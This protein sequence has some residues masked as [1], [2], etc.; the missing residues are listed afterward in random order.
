MERDRALAQ[1]R[2]NLGFGERLAVEILL[3]Q[4]VIQLGNLVD[5]QAA[6]FVESL[7]LLFGDG[8]FDHRF[9][10]ILVIREVVVDRDAADEVHDALES[11]ALANGDLHRDGRRA[12]PLENAVE[13]EL[14]IRAELVHFVDETQAWDT[15]FGGLPPHGFRLGLDAFLAIEDGHRAV[16][17]A[18]GALDLG[19]EIDVA[20]GVDQ[21]NGVAL[22]VAVP[23]AGGG[24]GVDRDPALLLFG[25]EVHGGG[26]LMHLAHFVDL[27]GVIEDS[28]GDG[29]LA[30]INV[31]GDAD[32]P[33]LAQVA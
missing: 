18:H 8:L 21:V 26:A 13:A 1:T 33:N 30:R 5:Q 14:K 7:F 24:R 19:G 20:G 29:G 3:G 16:E 28:L 27:A 2:A 17:H 32:I 10:A 4:L 11:A 31:G 12:Q 9:A 22:A 6:P 15:V 25:I 23:R